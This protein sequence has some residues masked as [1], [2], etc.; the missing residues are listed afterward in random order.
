MVSFHV[1]NK[2]QS[3]RLEVAK[4]QDGVVSRWCRHV[5]FCDKGDSWGEDLRD[6]AFQI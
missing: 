5:I 1:I 3:E 2:T 6:A 4:K